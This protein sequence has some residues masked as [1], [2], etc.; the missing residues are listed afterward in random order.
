[1]PARPIQER[2]SSLFFMMC[3]VIG[4]S[5]LYGMLAGVAA[6]HLFSLD[7][8]FAQLFV[9][10]PA[11]ITMGIYIAVGWSKFE[12]D[13][14]EWSCVQQAYLNSSPSG[15]KWYILSRW[16]P[17]LS[18][19]LALAWIFLC[20]ALRISSEFIGVGGAFLLCFLGLL[21]LEIFLRGARR[22]RRSMA[23]LAEEG[24]S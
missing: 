3:A 11:G 21:P 1:M 13:Q 15:A 8:H 16:S 14:L 5:L 10:L 17:Y 22:Y 7:R 6:M 2:L 18:G 9:A 19:F 23:K 24:N 20:A 4:C 12:N